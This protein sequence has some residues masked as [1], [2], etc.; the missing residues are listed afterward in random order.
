M[1]NV[2]QTLRA[3]DK[4]IDRERYTGFEGTGTPVEKVAFQIDYSLV[5]LRGWYS[6]HNNGGAGRFKCQPGG[7][8]S[9]KPLLAVV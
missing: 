4:E 5:W 6:N 1:A 7:Y 9:S 3:G 2:D 8:H